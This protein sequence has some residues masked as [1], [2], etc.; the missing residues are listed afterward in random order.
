MLLV[1]GFLWLT[2][3]DD[4]F[5]FSVYIGPLLSYFCEFCRLVCLQDLCDLRGE[6]LNLAVPWMSS[7]FTIVYIFMIKFALPLP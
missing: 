4:P 7:I 3:L 2:L 5:E 6:G 1:C